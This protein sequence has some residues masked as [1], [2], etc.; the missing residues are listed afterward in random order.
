M[1]KNLQTKE[2]DIIMTCRDDNKKDIEISMLKKIKE[3][4]EINS[5]IKNLTVYISLLHRNKRLF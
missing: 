2:K 4:L 5:N 1:L 3:L